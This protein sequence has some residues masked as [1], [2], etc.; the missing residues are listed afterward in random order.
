[1]P[2][3]AGPAGA[4]GPAG[5]EGDPGPTGPAGATGAAGPAGP[6]GPAGP[7]GPTGPQG[8]PGEVENTV[9][10]DWNNAKEPGFYSGNSAANRPT[11]QTAWLETIGNDFTGWVTVNG[12]RAMQHLTES[13]G[14]DDRWA[15]EYTRL[16]DGGQWLPW[17]DN[18]F[19]DTGWQDISSYLLSGMSGTMIGRRIGN[20]VQIVGNL[21][22][23]FPVGTS[24]TE[25]ANAL[26][27]MW[28][29]ARFNVQGG[30][31]Q[32]GTPTVAIMR[33]AGTMAVANRI[34]V[35][36]SAL[37]FSIVYTIGATSP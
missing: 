15:I 8:I 28:R 19:R 35:A 20:Q 30:G 2:G 3:P 11:G 5:P 16:W 10:T 14:A 29:P 36:A 18:D 6:I 22:G 4:T 25:I 13:G 9:V 37:Q 17:V 26:P 33:P 21:T 1:M 34:P 32:S 12:S 23:T 24:V 27:S 31:Y 7:T